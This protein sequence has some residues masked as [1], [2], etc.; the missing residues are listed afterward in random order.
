MT[1]GFALGE[2]HDLSATWSAIF[3]MHMDQSQR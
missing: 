3:H 2:V 1:P